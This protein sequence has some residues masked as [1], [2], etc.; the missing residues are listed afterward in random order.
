M[1][2]GL[3][4]SK[5]APL[6]RILN[7]GKTV[8]VIIT[9]LLA[10]VIWSGLSLTKL[11]TE[12]SIR[13]F[14]PKD[15]ILLK[16]DAEIRRTFQLNEQAPFLFIVTQPKGE[17]WLSKTQIDKLQNLSQALQENP[18]VAEVLSMTLV[19]GA[20]LEKNTLQVGNIFSRIPQEQWKEG[21]K[22]NPLIYPIL[23]T[24][25]FRSTLMAI[26]A[27]GNSTA[28][29]GH[30]DDDMKDLIQK[31]FPKAEILKAGV[32]LIQ[33]RLS[34]LIQSELSQFLLI[35]VVVFCGIFYFLFSHWTAIACAFLTLLSG[36]IFSLALLSAFKIPMNIVLVT[37]PVIVSVAI[38][39][40]LIHTLHLWSQN[41]LSKH[42]VYKNRLSGAIDTWLDLLTPNLLGSWT[43]ALGFLALV[44][45]PIPLI[46]QYGIAVALVVTAVS[47][48]SQLMILI[49]LPWIQPRMR[50]WFNKPAVWSIFSLRHAKL[51]IVLLLV[52]SF[53]G[54]GLSSKLNF[55]GRLFDD[56]PKGDP[57][58]AST[59]WMDKDY[60]GIVSY[61]VILK[62]QTPGFWKE[63]VALRKL[64]QLSKELRQISNVG[65][66]VTLTDFFQAQ[67]PQKKN[68]IAETFFMFSMAEKNPLSQILTEDAK[69]LRY[70]IR[71]KDVP[72]VQIDQTRAEIRHQISK[73]FSE[74]NIVEGGMAV[75]AHAINHDVAHDLVYGFWQSLVVIGLFLVVMFRSLR[76][77]LVACLPNFIP[78]AILMGALTMTGIAVK[79]GV[80]LIFSI[81]LGFA[82][83]NTV[84]LLSRLRSLM[85]DGK[86]PLKRALFMEA[87]PCLFE[88]FLMFVGFS[89]F[90]FSSFS[91]NQIFGV[92]MMISVVA[93]FFADLMFLP[94]LLKVFPNLLKEARKDP[95]AGHA[96]FNDVQKSATS[97]LRKV[98]S[99]VLLILI[100]SAPIAKAETPKDILEKSQARLDAHD[101][102]A[103]VEMKIIEKNGEVKSRLIQLKTLRGKE[104]YVLAKIESP[105]DIKGMGFLGQINKKG[106][107]SQWIYLPSSGQV[108][109]VVTGKTTA[110][111]LGSEI[112][113]EDLS[114][115]AIQSSNL[116]L[117]KSDQQAS[118]IEIIPASGTSGY[119]KVITQI[120]KKDSV[121]LSTEYYVGSRKKKT[122]T[123][124]QYLKLGTIWRAQIIEVKNHLN[125]RSTQLKFSQIKVNSG[126]TTKVFSQGALKED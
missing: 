65:S 92:F 59:E 117:S 78:P 62:T 50:T 39:S 31:E 33:A 100:L 52:V 110:G 115:E 18:Q 58:R 103:Q 105:A 3:I 1:D 66:I 44:L 124:L 83:N 49:A 81:A 77:A 25:D 87:N 70:M 22:S 61:D 79:P 60:G 88:S 123:F 97:P 69:N 42:P 13:Q 90:I 48:Y 15:H 7:S 91:M 86:F 75:G 102:Q 126:L 37:L 84:Y 96:S 63:P 41:P 74:V 121:P 101:D 21:I 53:L 45:S 119:S 34:Q 109:R 73:V 5:A 32:P 27:K 76:W 93:G 36:N 51:I 120:S 89:I 14:Y 113:P 71:L 104:F 94:A 55:S 54:G 38:M 57:V 118:W 80:A 11:Q 106:Q 111:L 6:K 125:G 4:G 95:A 12:Y 19:E 24:S 82:F 26:E 2:Q 64:S 8:K 72:T 67:I 107:E 98:A 99:Y 43:T 35:A 10:S 40:L 29:L 9:L 46:Y 56:L 23:V 30:F 116:R 122:V 114:S 16:N 85:K 68:E 17:S 20:S 47:I 108:R 28:E 112:S